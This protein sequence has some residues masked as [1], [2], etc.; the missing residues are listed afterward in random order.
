[1]S[2]GLNCY[3]AHLDDLIAEGWEIVIGGG[4]GGEE[5]QEQ[6]GGGAGEQLLSGTAADREVAVGEVAVRAITEAGA[7]AED[8]VVDGAVAGAGAG[9]EDTRE[10]R[11]RGADVDD[12]EDEIAGKRQRMGAEE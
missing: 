4:A 11:K 9:A 7:E 8:R 5:K 12:E 1:M 6:Q 2:D 3:A 10:K